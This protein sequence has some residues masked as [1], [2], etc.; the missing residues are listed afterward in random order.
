MLEHFHSGL[1]LWFCDYVFVYGLNKETSLLHLIKLLMCLPPCGYH[2][3]LQY[4]PFDKR[5]IYTQL[6]F[7]IVFKEQQIS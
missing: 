6:K 4:S 1:L 2:E 7:I 3:E 5:L